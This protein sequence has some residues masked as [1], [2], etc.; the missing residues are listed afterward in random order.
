MVKITLLIHMRQNPVKRF[1]FCMYMILVAAN[2]SDT[3]ERAR[4]ACAVRRSPPD[5]ALRGGSCA[6]AGLEA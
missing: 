6:K 3:S 1:E 4:R 2:T 5:A